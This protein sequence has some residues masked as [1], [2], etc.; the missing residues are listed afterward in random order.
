MAIEFL[1]EDEPKGFNDSTR[2]P[3][4]QE[5]AAAWQDLNR[6]WWERHP[7][8]YDFTSGI[9]C[10]EFSVEFY[11]EIDSRFYGTLWQM[12]PWRNRPF[13]PLI[14]F[15]LQRRPGDRRGLWGPCA[16]AR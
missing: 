13:D 8:R 2:L 4:S 10:P 6:S 14:D 1:S 7:M 3:P 9:Q 11:R 15:D 16:V 12:L 5:I